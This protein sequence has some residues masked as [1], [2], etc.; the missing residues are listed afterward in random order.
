MQG[1]TTHC[2][3]LSS[4]LSHTAAQFNFLPATLTAAVRRLYLNDSGPHVAEHTDHWDQRVTAHILLPLSLT[5]PATRPGLRAASTC[6]GSVIADSAL[7]NILPPVPTV[8]Q[9][10]ITYLWDKQERYTASS[11]SAVEDTTVHH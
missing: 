2:L 6:D 1:G 10:C 7:N 4:G 11:S 8:V 5:L 9:L 3:F